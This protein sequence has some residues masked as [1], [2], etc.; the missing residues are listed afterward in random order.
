MKQDRVHK[1]PSKSI[2]QS[3][4]FQV[5]SYVVGVFLYI[6]TFFASN[7]TSIIALTLGSI[8]FTGYM[9]IYEGLEDSIKQTLNRR[10]FYPNVHLLMTLGAL[11]AL[12]IGEYREAAL[13]IL[14]FAGAHLLEEFAEEKS[15]REISNLLNLHP[16]TARRLR[17]DGTTDMV[18][19]QDLQIDDQ[20][21]VLN[22]DQV[23]TDGIVISGRS[24]ID[25][26]SITGESM[27]VDVQEGSHVFGSTINGSGNF[28]F[29][30]TKDSQ[31]TVF[32]KIVELVSDAQQNVSQQQRLF[33]AFHRFM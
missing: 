24:T 26:S 2:I 25:Q 3:K 4:S 23:P 33:V 5:G 16:T 32:A 28:V 14:I 11:G 10:K 6:L 30:V 21:L 17:A 20:V 29:Q 27:P 31:D 7:S 18:D 12:F 15:S 19:V 1:M 22:G 9:V 8:F 13:L